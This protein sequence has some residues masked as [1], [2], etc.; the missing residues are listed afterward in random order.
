MK[1]P[2]SVR[3]SEKEEQIIEK[4]GINKTQFIHQAILAADGLDII[5][6]RKHVMDMVN[7]VDELGY[8]VTSEY[9]EKITYLRKELIN[10]CSM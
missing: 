4:S 9:K 7:V 8:S 2:T 10:L 6:I 3:L 5:N 1:N